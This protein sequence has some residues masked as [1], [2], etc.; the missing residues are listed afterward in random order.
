M[1][2]E[3]LGATK[4]VTGSCH[5]LKVGDVNIL[6]DCGLFQGQDSDEYNNELFSFKPEEINFIILS[7]SH[8]DHSGRIPLLFKNGCKGRVICTKPTIDLSEYI[9]KD[10]AKIQGEETYFKNL[11]R[12]RSNLEPLTPIYEL[13]DV[14]EALRHFEGYD[15]NETIKLTD[16]IKLVFRDAGHILGSAISEIKIKEDNNE[17]KIVF[18]GDLGNKN[19]DILKDPQ[20]CEGGDYVIMECTYGD[21]VHE[22]KDVYPEFL[23]IAKK[24][25][26]DGGNLIIPC[27]SL[28]R[29]QEIIYMLNRFVE[30]GS[31]NNCKVYVDSPLAT[32]LTEIFKR[33]E[34]YFDKEARMLISL[35]DDPLNFNGLHFIKTNEDLKELEKIKNGAI[36]I[37]AGGVRLSKHLTRN[38]PRE[39]CSI[40]ITAYKGKNS[41]GGKLLNGENTIKVSGKMV[42]V[43]S[44]VYYIGGLSCHADREGLFQWINSMDKKPKKIFLV[45][46]EEE[47]ICAFKE[48]LV[49]NEYDAITVEY[50]QCFHLENLNN[51]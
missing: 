31:L 43:K 3:F 41:Y 16:N 46:G 33:Y 44:K 14:D 29:T 40:I 11:E 17:V 4:C 23:L 30:S 36:I 9:L 20:I 35:G 12:K 42:D 10:A 1:K 51:N 24:T 48:K 8:I 37:A 50:G 32:S 38:L 7:H 21:K 15:Y 45:H 6:L 2:I 34:E 28:G 22:E 18:S 39:E 13:E 27:F 19:K 25:I 26:E 47:S 5:L 49:Q